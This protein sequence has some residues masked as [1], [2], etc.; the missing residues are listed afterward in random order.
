[1][2][3]WG[4]DDAVVTTSGADGGIDIQSSEAVAQVKHQAAPVGRPALQRLVGAREDP[5]HELFFFS[6]SAFA[7]PAVEYADQRAIALYTYGPY[8]EM[9]PR[10]REA[11]VVLSVADELQRGGGKSEAPVSAATWAPPRPTAMS[12][13]PEQQSH[14]ARRYLALFLAIWCLAVPF[15]A[16]IPGWMETEMYRG[17]WYQDFGEFLG[18]EALGVALMGLHVALNRDSRI[19]TRVLGPRG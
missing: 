14:W 11:R 3:Y 7:T 8:G 13:Q 4:Y 6:A 5:S 9:I 1:M 19:A 12:S 10:S 15:G 16:M 18:F 2:R 17:P